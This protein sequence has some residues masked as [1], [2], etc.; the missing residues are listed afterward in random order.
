MSC[1][2]LTPE[3][4]KKRKKSADKYT[5]KNIKL[6]QNRKMEVDYAP[7]VCCYPFS[8]SGEKSDFAYVKNR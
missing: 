3:E 4:K 2:T 8:P 5:N 1:H 7:S 6:I